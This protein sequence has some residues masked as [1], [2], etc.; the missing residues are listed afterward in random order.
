MVPINSVVYISEHIAIQRH[1]NLRYKS[2]FISKAS[3]GKQ[4]AD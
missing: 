4:T 2:T 3:Q 1:V